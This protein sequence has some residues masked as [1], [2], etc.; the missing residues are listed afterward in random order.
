MLQKIIESYELYKARR[1]AEKKFAR[2]GV[3]VSGLPAVVAKEFV[4]SAEIKREVKGETFAPFNLE[5]L[6][7]LAPQT[8]LVGKRAGP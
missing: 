4:L 7:L 2:K 8:H 3:I 1:A 6:N 5:R